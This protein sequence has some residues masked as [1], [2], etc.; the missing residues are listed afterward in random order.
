MKKTLGRIETRFFAYAQ[1]RRLQV[2]RLGEL[3]EPLHLSA[4]QELTLLSRLTRA[5]MIARVRRGLYLLPPRLP[6][7][8]KW[9]PDEILALNT[10]IEDRQ[11][12]Y[13][14]CG[15][16]AFHRYGYDEQVPTRLYAY[17]DQISGNRRI[18]ATAMTLI[19]I[20]D[21]RLGGTESFQTDEGVTAV[22][23]SRSRT[24]VDAVY[25]WSRFDS[26]P[27]AYDWIRRELSAGRISV[28][29][30]IFATVRYGNQG[31]VRRIGALLER[32]KVSRRLL[33]QLR[34][35]LK[36]SSSLIPWVPTKPKRGK[37]D[38]QWGVVFND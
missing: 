19:K 1:M 5:G 17:N 26:L 38:Q 28:T 22:Y 16:N 15:P 34:R 13:Q 18:G 3:A 35:S 25:D 24:L 31:T 4:R 30:L 9:S 36:P 21:K 12:R 7:G 23:S 6:L 29:E 11:G 27:R 33:T 14:I 32:E 2:V 8:G 37:A 10:L 20:S